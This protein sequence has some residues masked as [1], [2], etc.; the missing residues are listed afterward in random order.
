MGPVTLFAALT[1][2][3]YAAGCN[4]D[5]ASPGSQRGSVV[6]QKLLNTLSTANLDGLFSTGKHINTALFDL[7]VVKRCVRGIKRRPHEFSVRP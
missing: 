2:S 1:I 6:A 7:R 4:G 3:H 5:A